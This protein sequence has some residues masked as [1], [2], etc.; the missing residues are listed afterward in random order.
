MNQTWA[1]EQHPAPRSSKSQNQ[2][3]MNMNS[4][5]FNHRRHGTNIP[6]FNGISKRINPWS[7]FLTAG[8]RHSNQE[9]PITTDLTP[10]RG[11]RLV[12]VCDDDNLRL[13]SRNRALRFSYRKTLERLQIVANVVMPLAVV[14]ADAGDTRRQVYFQNRGWRVLVIL[15]ETTLTCS[16]PVVKSNADFDIVF[17]V[18]HLVSAG[19]FD[20]LLLATG[21]GDL[22]VAIG[23]GVRRKRPDLRLFTLSVAGSASARL[24]NRPDLYDGHIVAGRDLSRS[25]SGEEELH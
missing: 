13:Y 7:G 1:G 19:Q 20:T 8:R 24:R 15:R 23:R 18:G 10:L 12:V 4:R 22:A 21:D 11:T 14:M 2:S 6:R 17:E 5:Q 25:W 9:I 3:F 16:G